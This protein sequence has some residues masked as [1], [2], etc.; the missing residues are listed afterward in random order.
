[1]IVFAIV[2]GLLLVLTAVCITDMIL[3]SHRENRR[4]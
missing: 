2:T 1:M 4:G 3:K